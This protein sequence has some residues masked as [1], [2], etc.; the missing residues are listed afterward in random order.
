MRAHS[1]KLHAVAAALEALDPDLVA[2]LTPTLTQV[3]QT[4]MMLFVDRC[5]LLA[6]VLAPPLATRCIR[7]PPPQRQLPQRG[8]G[9]CLHRSPRAA[10]G[11][12]K[13][14]RQLSRWRHWWRRWGC[15]W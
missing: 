4:N 2:V 12:A 8:A 7:S 15:R 10:V 3:L 1:D 6:R 9:G 5:A 11:L 14:L 13:G